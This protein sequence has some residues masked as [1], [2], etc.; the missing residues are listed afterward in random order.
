MER[1]N[2]GIRGLFILVLI[3][4]VTSV[5]LLTQKT[6]ATANDTSV[7]P[8]APQGKCDPATQETADL[9][10]TYT[11]KVDYPDGGMTGDATLTITGSDFTL[12]AGSSTLSGK[13]S[14][15][16]TCGYIGATMMFGQW[17]LPKA[18]EAAPAVLPVVS[19][20]ARKA[21]SK[22]ALMSVPEEKRKFSFGSVPAPKKRKKPAAPPAPQ[23]SPSPGL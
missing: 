10:G 13:I 11:G 4:G 8:S 6:S 19:V 12:N 17:T 14:A 2:T 18:G 5:V 20:R 22:L 3:L 23:P 9:S 21:G 7:N 16:K 1:R 15:Q